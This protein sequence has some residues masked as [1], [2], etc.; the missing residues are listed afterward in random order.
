M[1]KTLVSIITTTYN[2]EK[3]IKQCIDSVLAQTYPYWEQIII[4][5]GSNDDTELIISRFKDKRIKY[6]KQKNKGIFKLNQS[7]NEALKHTNGKII[8][9]L[10]GD[11]FWPSDKLE[12]QILSFKDPEI[13]LSWGKAGFTDS[14]GEFLEYRPKSIDWL[15]KKSNEK[16]VDYLLFGNFIPACTVMCLKDTLTN[17]NGFKQPD[18]APYVDHL[19]WLEVSLEGKF[20]YID[21]TLGY[22]RH[23][24]NQISNTMSLEIFESLIYPINF[25]KRKSSRNRFNVSI[26]D[27]INFN[28]VQIKYNLLNLL[29]KGNNPQNSYEKSSSV[30]NSYLRIKIITQTIYT[31]LKIDIIWMVVIIQNSI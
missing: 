6:I 21:H 26:L 4:D 7:Y 14:N 30:R 10:E 11:D 18:K 25:F 19:T 5:D 28:L 20:K 27:L 13:V 12:K 1:D 17:I 23:H 24:E 29:K 8:A 15:K 31:V 16:L 3:F 9:I 2:H 22:W